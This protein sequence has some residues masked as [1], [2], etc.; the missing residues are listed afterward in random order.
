MTEETQGAAPEAVVEDTAAALAAEFGQAP[1]VEDKPEGDEDPDGETPPEPEAAEGEQPK[2]PKKTA[3]ERID[4]LTWR[5]RETERREAAL[6][7]RFTAGQPPATAP[8]A[9]AT[10]ADDDPEPSPDEYVYGEND[11]AYV[12]DLARYEARQEFKAL[13]SQTARQTEAER[14][15]SIH[16]QREAAFKAK[17]P[18]F[19]EVVVAGGQQGKWVCTA[20]MAEAIR[21]SE[22]GPEVAYHL[23][24]NPDEAARIAAL[25]Q[26]AQIREIGK[27]EAKL[28][29]PAPAPAP[30]AKTITSAPEPA[31]AL[32]G[33]SGQFKV[34]P[35]TSDFSAFEKAY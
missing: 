16:A 10:T 20:D 32:R 1:A 7:D 23:A 33:T 28:A 22:A 30:A 2:P 31:P 35:D 29:I 19:D 26:V 15:K 3:K 18:D 25:S 34:G 5:L 13:Q 14:I 12:K 24:K 21:T 4:E 17:A 8:Q 9:S 6:L 11:L 27:L